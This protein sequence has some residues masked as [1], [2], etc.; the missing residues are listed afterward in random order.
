MAPVCV[1]PG[2]TD[3]DRGCGNMERR[4]RRAT[5]SDRVGRGWDS[6]TRNIELGCLEIG[7]EGGENM[8]LMKKLH[9]IVKDFSQISPLIL[10][11]QFLNLLLIVVLVCDAF[12]RPDMN[13]FPFSDPVREGGD[14][15]QQRTGGKRGQGWRGISNPGE[16]HIG[17]ALIPYLPCYLSMF[18]VVLISSPCPPAPRI[19]FMRPTIARGEGED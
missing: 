11:K 3:L 1:T 14:G 19:M 10:C 7:G 5:K 12:L 4:E 15:L 16:I 18:F 17:A 2:F 8:S 6:D 13:L 9:F